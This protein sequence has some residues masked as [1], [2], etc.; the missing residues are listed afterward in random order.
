MIRLDSI[1][2]PGHNT[3]PGFLDLVH[4]LDMGM[5]EVSV[6]CGGAMQFRPVAREF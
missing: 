6:C 1:G 4:D 5:F 2:D 3:G